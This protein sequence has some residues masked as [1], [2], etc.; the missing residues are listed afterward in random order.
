MGSV[1]F[2]SKTYPLE[3]NES[4]LDCLLRHGINIPH[5]C[6]AGACQSC[7]MRSSSNLPA[8]AQKGLKQSQKELG[9]FLSC[10]CIPTEDIEAA[11]GDDLLE[12]HQTQVLDIKKLNSQIFRIRLHAPFNFK[13]GQYINIW[14]NDVITRSYSIASTASENHIELHVKVLENGRFSSWAYNH[15]NVGDALNIQGPIGDCIYTNDR[16]DA[17]ILMAGIGTGL[18]PLFGILKDALTAGHTGRIQLLVG[19]REAKNFY[20]CETLNSL[21]E[22]HANLEVRFSANEGNHSAID[23]QIF[24]RESIYDLAKSIAPN[25]Q[26]YRIYLCGAPTF[27]NKMRKQCFLTGASMQDIHCDAFLPSAD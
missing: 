6:K 1:I 9:Y 14:L 22:R 11:L 17:P 13:A 27:V 12:R 26:G 8:I 10:S 5:G 16:P 19:A 4:V 24:T 20:L 18:A 23:P 3:Q 21:A 2:D 15:L 25:A 7:V